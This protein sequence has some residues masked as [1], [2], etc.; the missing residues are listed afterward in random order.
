MSRRRCPFRPSPRWGRVLRLRHAPRFPEQPA[1]LHLRAV[2]A[3]RRLHAHHEVGAGREVRREPCAAGPGTRL[4]ERGYSEEPP[5]LGGETL[6]QYSVPG[7]S[8]I[9]YFIFPF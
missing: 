4:W 2:E 9:F 3:E 8:D 6:L 5:H 1:R 7:I